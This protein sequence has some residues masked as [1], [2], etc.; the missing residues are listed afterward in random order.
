MSKQCPLRTKRM[1]CKHDVPT[2]TMAQE[3]GRLL[4]QKRGTCSCRDGYVV[5]NGTN[6]CTKSTPV[7]SVCS[8]NSECQMKDVNSFCRNNFPSSKCTCIEGFGVVDGICIPT[9][10]EAETEPIVLVAYQT[11][12]PSNPCPTGFFMSE[13]HGECEPIDDVRSHV[14]IFF[15]WVI[16]VPML[17][18]LSVVI[19][20]AYQKKQLFRSSMNSFGHRTR[21]SFERI[22]SLVRV[23]SRRFRTLDPE[24]DRSGT[25]NF[26][27]SGQNTPISVAGN[28]NPIT[29]KSDPPPSYLDAIRI[30]LA[31]SVIKESS[32]PI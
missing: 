2:V 3:L 23:Q 1:Y 26:L 6:S 15:F 32:T 21:H 11:T 20:F 8:R 17:I 28:R 22:G 12:S 9:K 25:E 7:G 19:L 30:D 5:K 13:A 29:G 4:G 10:L 27:R 24:G 18:L 16:L 31:D 14:M